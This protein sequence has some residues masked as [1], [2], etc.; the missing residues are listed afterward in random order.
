MP[1]TEEAIRT[2]HRLSHGESQDAGQYQEKTEPIIERRPG[3]S[4]GVRFLPVAAGKGDGISDGGTGRDLHRI[5]K[6]R[7]ISPLVPM[8][9]VVLDFLCIHPFRDGNGRAARLLTV[10]LCYHAGAEVA[11][12]HHRSGTQRFRHAGR[13]PTSSARPSP[14][15]GDF[16]AKRQGHAWL[17]FTPGKPFA[18]ELYD[19]ERFWE[20]D[21]GTFKG[22]LVQ[23]TEPKPPMQ[24]SMIMFP[25]GGR[26]HFPPAPPANMAKAA[27]SR[28]RTTAQVP[29]GAA[30]PRRHR[31]PQPA[32]HHEHHCD[33]TAWV[34]A[35]SELKPGRKQ[36]T[37]L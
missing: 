5:Q 29:D 12:C 34:F 8:G 3:Q 30:I 32:P 24:G 15:K 27:W 14:K 26:K 23:I 10:L 9:G 1:V 31:V 36:V 35:G 19:D 7:R 33:L 37:M 28:S 20:R 21:G 17:R 2:L 11:I 25:D 13:G 16:I 22:P 18:A 4:D 6:D